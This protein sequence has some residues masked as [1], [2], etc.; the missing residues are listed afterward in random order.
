MLKTFQYNEKNT[1]ENCVKQLE[2]KLQISD[3]FSFGQCMCRGNRF[4]TTL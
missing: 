1:S 4:L 3:V 2:A